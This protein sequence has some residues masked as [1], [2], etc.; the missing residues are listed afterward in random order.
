[1]GRLF[2][3]AAEDKAIRSAIR[4]DKGQRQPAFWSRAVGRTSERRQS[5]TIRA[6]RD[7]R[8]CP[9]RRSGCPL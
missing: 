8:V 2:D 1:L 4:D 3:T 5:L 7:C 9:I 6:L